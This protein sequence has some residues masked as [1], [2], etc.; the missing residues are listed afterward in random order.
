MKIT[1]LSLLLNLGA[2]T[3]A[4]VVGQL[5]CSFDPALLKRKREQFLLESTC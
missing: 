1:F 3:A 4:F 2:W 5:N